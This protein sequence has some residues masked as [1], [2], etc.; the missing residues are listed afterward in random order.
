MSRHTPVM[1]QEVVE[2]LKLSP[3]MVIVDCTVGEGGHSEGILRKIT[4]DGHLIGIDQDDDALSITRLR[5][6]QFEG[7]FTL[8][9]N[10]FQNIRD[11]IAA[12]GRDAMDGVVFDLGVSMMQLGSPERGFSFQAD[13]P[14]NMRMDKKGQITAFDLV[15]N[16][17][18]EEI[19][20]II[21][22]FGEERYSRR[23][24]A[25]IV[26]ERSRH[27]IATTQQL[28]G[29]VIDAMPRHERYKK[30][31]PATRTFMALRI[32]VNRELEVL[33]TGLREAIDLLKSGGRIC[34]I[35]FHSLEDR[36]VKNEFK[37]QARD[38]RVRIITKKPLIP[39]DAEME[40]NRKSRSAK[41]RVAEKI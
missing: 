31:H 15:N 18:E 38:G 34:V 21:Y 28:A 13:G 7:S 17:S 37:A 14:L 1:A 30:I 19:A 4:P 27:A 10:N 22:R 9:E 6:S 3:G 24:A 40:S 8:V 33:Q 16:L 29:I 35:S 20:N 41:L 25:A 26:A 23:I 39:T 11:V 12:V 2:Y 32:A 36:I 5:L